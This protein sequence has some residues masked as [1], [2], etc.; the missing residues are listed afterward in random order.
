MDSP[1]RVF[2]PDSAQI[3]WE[4]FIELPYSPKTVI[5]FAE[6]EQVH[7]IIVERRQMVFEAGGGKD[8]LIVVSGWCLQGSAQDFRANG[9]NGRI[10]VTGEIGDGGNSQTN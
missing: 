5:S 4:R 7:C 10:A 8:D 2:A 6:H 3:V 9:G 1:V